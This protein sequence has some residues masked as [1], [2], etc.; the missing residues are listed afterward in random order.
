MIW[1]K[2]D[3]LMPREELRRLQSERLKNTVRRVY[4]NVPFYREK[5]NAAGV[6]PKDIRSIDDI[7]LLPFT[8]KDDLRDNYPYGLFAAPM[9]D[10][11]RLQASSGTTGTP[12]GSGIYSKG[13]SHLGRGHGARHERSRSRPPTP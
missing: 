9:E 3:E 1:N 11:V 4:D 12:Y 13:H 6:K 7:A 8:V 2:T 10:I 5:M